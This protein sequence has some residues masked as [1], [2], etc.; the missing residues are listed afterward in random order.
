MKK[1]EKE[2]QHEFAS[3]MAKHNGETIALEKVGICVN[4]GVLKVGTN[5]IKI[6]NERIDMGDKPIDNASKVEINSRLKV[7]VGADMYD[8]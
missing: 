6:S 8:V 3:L 1:E 7:P 2:C 4:C 5:T